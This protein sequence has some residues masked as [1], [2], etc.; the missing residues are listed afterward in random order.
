MDVGGEIRRL[1]SRVATLE[2][3]KRV[4]EERL[5]YAWQ[6]VGRLR[7]RVLESRPALQT[8]A[9]GYRRVEV[10]VVTPVELAAALKLLRRVRP[11]QLAS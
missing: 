4:L 9:P 11:L 7:A 3:D 8:A 2:D 10:E 1:R 6:E 5:A